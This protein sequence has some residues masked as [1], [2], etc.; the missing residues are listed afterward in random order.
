MAKNKF[1]E[2]LEVFTDKD[3]AMM[4]QRRWATRLTDEGKGSEF[5]ISV[6]EGSG[7]FRTR[8]WSVDLWKRGS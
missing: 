1:V 8:T 6:S 2:T 7:L 4:G 5:F 3:A